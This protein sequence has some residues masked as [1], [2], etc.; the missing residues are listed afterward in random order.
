MALPLVPIIAALAAGGSLVPHAAGGMIVTSV[1]GYVAGTYLSTAAIGGLLTAGAT[2]LGAGT[3]ALTGA[4]G[5]IIGGAGIFGT[6]VGA[7]GITGALM[8]AGIISATPIWV[9]VA[10]AGA[11]VTSVAGMG[12]GSY[13]L[14]KLKQKIAETKDGEE[15]HFSDVDAKIVERLIRR[16][17]KKKPKP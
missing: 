3:L 17:N 10:V 7:T 4:A 12:Y 2:A 6:S 13:K 9:P 1:G 16:L 14:I 8:S 11:A 15:A 5:S